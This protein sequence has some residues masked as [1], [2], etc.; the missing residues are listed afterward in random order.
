MTEEFRR[1]LAAVGLT[2]HRGNCQCHLPQASRSLSSGPF[3]IGFGFFDLSS[4]NQEVVTNNDP[5]ICAFHHS[6][7]CDLLLLFI[8]FVMLQ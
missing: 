6:F 8:H 2:G 4:A 7:L 5:V 1:T 3:P